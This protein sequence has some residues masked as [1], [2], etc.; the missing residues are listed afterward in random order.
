VRPPWRRNSGKSGSRAA[1][2]KA[3][4]PRK[5]GRSEAESLDAGEHGRSGIFERLSGSDEIVL[6]RTPVGPFAF[7]VHLG[8]RKPVRHLRSRCQQ[9]PAPMGA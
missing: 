8:R 5:R 6:N 7:G 1:G 2:V 4:A 9:R 3:Y